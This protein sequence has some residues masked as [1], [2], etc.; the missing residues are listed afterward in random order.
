ME[1]AQKEKLYD[2]LIK[3]ALAVLIL[4]FVYNIVNILFLSRGKEKKLWSRVQDPIKV[5]KSNMVRSEPPK[6]EVQEIQPYMPS[7]VSIERTSIFSGPKKEKITEAPPPP[8]P[9]PEVQEIV[10]EEGDRFKDLVDTWLIFKGV[11]DDIALINVRRNINEQ[12][13]EHSFL[14]R[15]GERIGEEKIIAKRKV[16]L[17]TNCLLL[18]I[19]INAQRAVTL[20]KKVVILDEEGG[21]VGTRMAPGEKFKK[22]VPKIAFRDEKGEIQDLWLGGEVQVVEKPKEE[23]KKTFSEDPLGVIKDKFGDIKESMGAPVISDEDK[24]KYKANRN[25]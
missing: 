11:T 12:L 4:F 2:Y 21:F 14:I 22:N 24:A 15:I 13:K 23:E 6:P 25:Y 10:I 19:A 5:V 8:P 7:V 17:T 16:D 20:R 18:D 1:I 9:K 3:I